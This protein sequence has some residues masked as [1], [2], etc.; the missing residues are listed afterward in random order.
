MPSVLQE[1]VHELKF[2]Q[3]TVLLTAIRGPDGIAKYSPPKM[4]L[5]WYRRCVLISA[6]DARVIEDPFDTG[7][8]SFTG[9]SLKTLDPEWNAND[10]NA[11]MHDSVSEYLKVLDCIPTHF[12]MHFLHACEILGYKHPSEKIRKFWLEVYHRFVNE[13]HLNPE[14]ELEMDQRLGDNREGWLNKADSAT[15]E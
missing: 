10:W 12:H 7:G 5:R 9:P 8:G 11:G 6:M 3:Q 2:M 13:M 14:T 1:W 15:R 4:L